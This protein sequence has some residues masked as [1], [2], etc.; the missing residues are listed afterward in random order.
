MGGSIHIHGTGSSII[1][2]V[3][4]CRVNGETNRR[5]IFGS[6]EELTR[7]VRDELGQLRLAGVKPSMGDIRCITFGHLTRMAIWTLRPSWNAS[8][9]PACCP[10]ASSARSWAA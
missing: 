9:S 6:M 7:S 3:F 1:D 5:H 2:T 10:T 8:A 4:V